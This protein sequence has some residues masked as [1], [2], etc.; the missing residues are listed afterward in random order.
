M[1]LGKLG[2]DMH[3]NEPGPPSY[4]IHKNKLK[5]DERPKHKIG[6]Y[7]NP[8]GENKQQPL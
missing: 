5:M 6:N 3:K 7:Q 8:T 2:G 1:Q 4:T